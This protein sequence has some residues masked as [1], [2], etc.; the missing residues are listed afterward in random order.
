MRRYSLQKSSK[1]ICDDWCV[2]EWVEF[3]EDI[4]K[5]S[6][7]FQYTYGYNENELYAFLPGDTIDELYSNVDSFID[8][9]SKIGVNITRK[10]V[11]IILFPFFS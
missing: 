6:V 9:L 4:T 8:G 7:S 5:R 10:E 2:D 3:L 11:E 1:D